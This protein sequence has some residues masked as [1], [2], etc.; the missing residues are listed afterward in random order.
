[1]EWIAIAG[2][3]AMVVGSVINFVSQ[4]I[5]QSQNR[6]EQ[7]G[8]NDLQRE[9]AAST[10]QFSVEQWE[11]ENQYNLPSAQRQRLIDAGLNPGIMYGN[12]L[13]NEAAQSPA[14]QIPNNIDAYK[15]IAPQYDAQAA[16]TY[17]EVENIQAQTERLKTQ[18]QV[19]LGMLSNDQRRLIIEQGQLAEKQK[20]VASYCADIYSIIEQRGKDFDLRKEM[21]EFSK[22]VDDEK[23]KQGWE[24]LN[25]SKENLRIQLELLPYMK[26]EMFERANMY[27]AEAAKAKTEKDILDINYR[28]E[29]ELESW[30]N[31]ITDV[32]RSAYQGDF[33]ADEQEALARQNEAMQHALEASNRGELATHKFW[34]WVYTVWTESLS[35]IAGGAV[36]G[37]AA[38]MGRASSRATSRVTKKVGNQYTTTWTYD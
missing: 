37:A 3:I 30:R 28:Y 12:G 10:N 27:A 23:L 5:T 29:Q 24:Q 9:L 21:F 8:I 34:Y 31:E 18:N 14:F 7:H 13:M 1:M 19:D 11:R 25:I 26:R 15:S 4:G 22:H 2:A 17:A 33:F 35:S 20:E 16:K 36:G 38:R 32:R 6:E